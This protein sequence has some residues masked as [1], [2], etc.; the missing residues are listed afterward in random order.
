MRNT[1]IG[2]IALF[3]LSGCSGHLPASVVGQQIANDGATLP[4]GDAQRGQVLVQN[5]CSSCHT[6]QAQGSDGL[7]SV[8]DL[9]ARA[10]HGAAAIRRFLVQPHKPMPP[11]DLTPQEIE[12]VVA[13]LRTRAARTPSAD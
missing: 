3:L 2:A 1:A 8:T 13:Y 10:D 9:A 7:P 12:D 11:L 5:W 4:Y 6:I